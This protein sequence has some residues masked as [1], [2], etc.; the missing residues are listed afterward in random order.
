MTVKKVWML[1][2]AS[3]FFAPGYRFLAAE[4]AP[5]KPDSSRPNQP[6]KT[7]SQTGADTTEKPD[8]PTDTP[9]AKP[10]PFAVPPYASP[11]QLMKFVNCLLER[12]PPEMRAERLSHF[13]KLATAIL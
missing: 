2:V 5:P 7:E 13:K 6:S 9:K 8:A 12:D 3:L 1:L 10:D 4:D 11:V